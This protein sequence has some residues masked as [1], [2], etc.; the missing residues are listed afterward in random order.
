MNQDI[1]LDELSYDK[2]FNEEEIHKSSVEPSHHLNNLLNNFEAYSDIYFDK[3]FVN[4]EDCS[5]YD[6]SNYPKEIDL[7][8]DQNSE[9]EIFLRPDIV[10]Y[11][12]F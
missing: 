3:S 2:E 6:M 11:R 4:V 5:A 9:E 12:A 8:D 7:E 1:S 10:D